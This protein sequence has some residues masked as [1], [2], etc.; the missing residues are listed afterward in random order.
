MSN[1]CHRCGFICCRCWLLLLLLLA[2]CKAN[3]K[4]SRQVLLPPL[5]KSTRVEAAASIAQG[6]FIGPVAP[7]KLRL[8]WNKNETDTD[9]VTEIWTVD[10]NSGE[11]TFFAETLGTTLE[12]WADQQAQFFIARNRR[13]GVVSPW[14]I[15]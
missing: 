13:Y 9:V 11:L 7:A 3:E 1:R 12:L 8:E 6:Q 4:Q 15:K 2:G 14:N 5:P 10:I